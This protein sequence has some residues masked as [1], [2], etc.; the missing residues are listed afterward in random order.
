[1]QSDY[2]L[3]ITLGT[4]IVLAPI[5]RSLL[6]RIGV[7]ALVGYIGLGYL[8]AGVKPLRVDGV[9]GSL[10]NVRAGRYALARPLF[11]FT[12][13]WPEGAALEF[14]DYVLHPGAG[15]R[16]IERAG[17]IPMNAGVGR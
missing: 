2:P 8:N 4:L 6:E 11:L 17:L 14:I 16:V 9:I 12:D 5:I 1:M 15:Q 10:G 7:P 3:L 13:G